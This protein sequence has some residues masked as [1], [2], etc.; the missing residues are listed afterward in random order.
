MAGKRQQIG[1]QVSRATARFQRVPARKVRYVTE[2]IR[3]LTVAEARTVLS[4]VHRPSAAPL[5]RQV[6]NSAAANSQRGDAE[7]LVVGRVH[8][9]GGPILK[10]WRPRA[11]GRAAR[12]RK[13]LSHVTIELTEPIG[14]SKEA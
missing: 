14:R 1:A 4:L 11:F 6:L 10:R 3:G 13:R 12:I 8:V 9:D 2:L 7:E 5:V